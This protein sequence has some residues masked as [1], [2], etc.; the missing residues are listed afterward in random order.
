MA[1][2]HLV[3]FFN[4]LSIE[5]GLSKNT[6]S[7]YQ[8]DLQKY[9][10]YLSI[11]SQDFASIQAEDLNQYVAWLRGKAS[12]NKLGESSIA[13][14]VIAI[15][16]F[17]KYLSKEHGSKDIASNFH[18]P[19]IPKRLPKALSIDQITKILSI[20]GEDLISVRDRALLE[21]LYSTGARVTEVINL[22]ISDIS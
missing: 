16:N 7:S 10:E 9:F 17:Y 14:N 8:R 2:D 20:A 15:R 18:P 3:D 4:Y 21:I 12:A 11:N 5:K 6:V 1:S 13:R 19:K 22:D